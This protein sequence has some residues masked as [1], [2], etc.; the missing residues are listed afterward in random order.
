MPFSLFFRENLVLFLLLFAVIAAIIIYEMK[1]KKLV[2]KQ[3][4]AHILTKLVNEGA[5]LL[6]IRK[7]DAFK[8]AKISGAKNVEADYFGDFA[9]K[10]SDKNQAIILYDD[11]GFDSK[12]ASRKLIELGFSQVFIL[13]S[14]LISWREANLP[15]I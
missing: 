6:D 14:G 9:Q 2:G 8:K 1:D 4:S 15:L 5:I 3:I 11:N 7:P 13:K 12:N 10:I